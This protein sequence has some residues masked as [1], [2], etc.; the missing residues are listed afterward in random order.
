M[1]TYTKTSLLVRHHAETDAAGNFARPD[2][3]LSM[4]DEPTFA[5]LCAAEPAFFLSA[6]RDD[7]DLEAHMT[8]A[9]ASMRIV[10]AA[11]AS[12]RTKQVVHL[13]D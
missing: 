9:V 4:A 2:E 8:A 7:L 3:R 11:D 13:S 10:L 12:I 5:E 6:I 1:D